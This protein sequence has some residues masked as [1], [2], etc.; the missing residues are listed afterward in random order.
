MKSSVAFNVLYHN[1]KQDGP[2][3]LYV[4]LEETRESLLASMAGL[5]MDGRGLENKI[6]VLDLGLIR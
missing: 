4:T 6:N 2:G 3:G 5:G 1:A